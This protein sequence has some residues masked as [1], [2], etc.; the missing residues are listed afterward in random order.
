M[1]ILIWNHWTIWKQTWL[2]GALGGLQKCRDLIL[3]RL[4]NFK[5]KTVIDNIHIVYIMLYFVIVWCKHL[6]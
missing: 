4:E 6:L 5:I 3:I 1:C 2:E